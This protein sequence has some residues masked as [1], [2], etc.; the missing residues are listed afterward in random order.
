MEETYGVLGPFHSLSKFTIKME[1]IGLWGH[2]NKTPELREE[3]WKNLGGELS[4]TG[5]SQHVWRWAWYE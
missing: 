3:M 2:S 1:E 5:G 4:G